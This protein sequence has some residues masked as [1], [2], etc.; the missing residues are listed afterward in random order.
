V[1]SGSS[2]KCR[3]WRCGWNAVI[4]FS[5]QPRLRAGARRRATA[6]RPRCNAMPC[7]APRAAG[8]HFFN[9]A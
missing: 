5:L 4:S 9:D 8:D 3:N 6:L 2:E 1:L 7:G